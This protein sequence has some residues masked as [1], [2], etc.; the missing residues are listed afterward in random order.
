MCWNNQGRFRN[1]I[2]KRPLHFLN[3]S[4]Q[5]LKS[6]TSVCL[7][8]CSHMRKKRKRKSYLPTIGFLLGLTVLCCLLG[9]IADICRSSGPLIG[10]LPINRVGSTR[11]YP[12][13]YQVTKRFSDE[14]GP[15]EGLITRAYR[16][17]SSDGRYV[18]VFMYITPTNSPDYSVGQTITVT[19][20]REWL[21]QR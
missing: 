17:L 12:G 3:F 6:K 9:Y 14:N 18:D 8:P 19:L 1:Y 13:T 20:E 10:P 4:V 21:V 2:G 15:S 5:Y 16:L 11:I 7:A